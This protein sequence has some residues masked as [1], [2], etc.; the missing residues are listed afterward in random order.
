MLKGKK[1]V[2]E[3]FS[4][5][6]SYDSNKSYSTGNSRNHKGKPD[7]TGIY[8]YTK[9]ISHDNGDSCDDIKNYKTGSDKSL[10]FN[11]LLNI[12]SY[13]IMSLVMRVSKIG[14]YI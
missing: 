9:C 14:K 2:T 3:V 8:Q 6:A 1:E 4:F 5:G 10:I 12:F 11:R 13:K 7:G